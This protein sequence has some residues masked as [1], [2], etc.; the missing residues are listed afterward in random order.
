M[1]RHTAHDDAP[2]TAATTRADASAEVDPLGLAAA[3]QARELMSAAEAGVAGSGQALPHGDVIQQAFGHHDL[4]GVSAHVG[5]SA[6]LA[7]QTLG[8]QAYATGQALAFAEPPDLHTAA[9]EAAHAVQQRSGGGAQVAARG[10]FGRPGD[11]HE[12]H[13]DAV[14]DAVVDKR[15]AEALL[16]AS[17]G[18]S[19]GVQL[20]EK[21]TLADKVAAYG[22][23]LTD[24][25][26]AA[27]EGGLA[28]QEHAPVPV[29]IGRT[30]LPDPAT[31]ELM[32]RYP[33]RLGELAD[34][35]VGGRAVAAAGRAEHRR[36]DWETVDPVSEASRVVLPGERARFRD[37]EGA[38]QPLVGREPGRG[39][40]KYDA[41]KFETAA[42]PLGEAATVWAEERRRR[43]E[44]AEGHA[45]GLSIAA[46]DGRQPFAAYS[47]PVEVPGMAAGRPL[48]IYDFIES[49]YD[50]VVTHGDLGGADALALR[51]AVLD[52]AGNGLVPAVQGTRILSFEALRGDEI[53]TWVAEVGAADR[54]RV[55]ARIAT[56]LDAA[57]AEGLAGLS[58]REIMQASGERRIEMVER[59]MT[60]V[61]SGDGEGKAL[62]AKLLATMSGGTFQAMCERFVTGGQM[63]AF[64]HWVD[65]DAELMWLFGE[66]L[67]DA[68]IIYDRTVV[69]TDGEGETHS[70]AQGCMLWVG[71]NPTW[72]GSSKHIDFAGKEC[73]VQIGDRGIF[74]DFAD[75]GRMIHGTWKQNTKG[76]H[77]YAVGAFMSGALDF[78]VECGIGTLD[79]LDR[80]ADVANALYMVAQDPGA[81][82]DAI[83]AAIGKEWETLLDA[84][85][86]AEYQG[87]A[88]E[89]Y[90]LAGKW[91]TAITTTVAGLYGLGKGGLNVAKGIAKLR[92]RDI[93]LYL[94]TLLRRS[95]RLR[96]RRSQ[97]K[98][99]YQTLRGNPA[100]MRRVGKDAAHLD[101]SIL[102]AR[103]ARSTA[104]KAAQT[105]EAAEDVAQAQTLA[106]EAARAAAKAGQQVAVRQ[107][108]L[109]RVLREQGV[110]GAEVMRPEQLVKF[111]KA[112]ADDGIDTK[113]L[114]TLRRELLGDLAGGAPEIEGDP[115]AFGLAVSNE[116]S[117]LKK[118]LKRAN[119]DAD[120]AQ[121][122]EQSREKLRAMYEL[123]DFKG[124]SELDD[125][126]LI[127]FSNQFNPHAVGN[128]MRPIKQSARK[129]RGGDL[130]PDQVAKEL[131]ALAK[132][133]DKQGLAS[134][135]ATVRRWIDE[136]RDFDYFTIDDM[137]D[138]LAERATTEAVAS[139]VAQ[140]RT[141]LAQ[142]RMGLLAKNKT[143]D[144]K[145]MREAITKAMSDR[146][147]LDLFKSEK[148]RFG[149][150]D[151]SN[152]AF[153]DGL[154]DKTVERLFGQLRESKFDAF[155]GGIKQAKSQGLE[156]T[157]G[158]IDEIDAVR[159]GSKGLI[160][161]HQNVATAH[162]DIPGVDLDPRLTAVSGVDSPAGTVVAPEQRIFKTTK[163]GHDRIH[164]SE[165]KILEAI[166][167]RLG[168]S[169]DTKGSI[170][171]VSERPCCPSCLG[172]IQQ[173]RE[174]YPHITLTVESGL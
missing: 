38:P 117:T 81:A 70:V 136:M 60:S 53:A 43:Q 19:P 156:Q 161:A 137:L 94:R 55:E 173:F 44:N 160:H 33:Q 119:K 86:A 140:G 112:L 104:D 74:G 118:S 116:A 171:L 51:T 5:G 45:L 106:T 10:G 170:T 90:Y 1:N 28:A 159:D 16:D 11:S 158:K 23:T 30:V 3:G 163:V 168:D 122:A 83:W 71:N 124:I 128:K 145:Q 87:D 103:K 97:G 102:A 155:E 72:G 32:A 93:A 153:V 34:L 135:A 47:I 130:T 169:P 66:R 138:G 149:V 20:K 154:P 68:R 152:R 147:M 111:A 80:P 164:D 9:H 59:V 89:Y 57:G 26:S 91:A 39:K 46:A 48:Y 167:H 76:S 141:Q 65:G 98:G 35:V 126:Q 6:A 73:T 101:D 99:V 56:Q 110:V 17:P 41:I 24:E 172:V 120:A 78:T 96:P 13:A 131:E 166:A 88:T 4:G 113:Q 42:T 69:E 27:V 15:S 139:T 82:L 75:V 79:M 29:Q 174:R 143:L 77:E 64:G 62:V 7:A 114:T 162:V 142:T 133:L 58:D 127:G 107:A 18:G 40:G 123:N 8:A 25:A 67:I 150:D 165:A 84:A 105:A 109:G 148:A 125:Q 100:L 132:T 85:H 2:T 146:G 50:T 52:A 49:A 61:P 14:A 22:E 115:A 92:P 129:I 12:Q 121:T 63:N 21:T 108:Q 54:A 95:G 157:L 134:E 151:I 36:A 37:V 31:G 144:Q